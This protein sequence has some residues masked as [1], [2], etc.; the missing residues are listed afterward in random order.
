MEYGRKIQ[1][2]S[3]PLFDRLQLHKCKSHRFMEAIS[4]QLPPTYT[5]VRF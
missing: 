3:L 4:E 1:S 5:L 2:Q